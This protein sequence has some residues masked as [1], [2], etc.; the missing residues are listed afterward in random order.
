RQ[1]DAGWLTAGLAMVVPLTLLTAYRLQILM[2]NQLSLPVKD[3]VGLILSA[4][5]LNLVLPSKMGDIAKAYFLQQRGHLS[6]SLALSL[7]IVEK[8]WDLLSLLFWCLLGLIFLPKTGALFWVLTGLIAFGIL[9]GGL[10]LG[11]QRAAEFVFSR[12]GSIRSQTVQVKVERMAQAWNEMRQAVWIDRPKLIYLSQLSLLI[13]FLHLVQVWLFILALKG[14]VPF[15]A[16]LGLT[17]LAILAGL[18]PLTFA[19]VGTRDAGLIFFYRAYLPV[20]VAAALGLLCTSR[21]VLP[22]MAGVPFFSRH[23]TELRRSQAL[24]R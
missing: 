16:S 20:P 22:A 2:P 7:V 4:S 5:V 1:C 13:W 24:H 10:V 19:G 17:P 14:S 18:L 6:G 23:I 12:L 3:A 9:A 11:S 15:L 21:Y 8:T